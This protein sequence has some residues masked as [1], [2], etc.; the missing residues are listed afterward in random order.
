MSFARWD[1]GHLYEF[2]LATGARV[3]ADDDEGAEPGDIEATGSTPREELGRVPDKIVP[4]FGWVRYR[5]STAAT[6]QTST[7]EL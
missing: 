2:R 6:R 3:I 1:I 7:T 4:M 5:T